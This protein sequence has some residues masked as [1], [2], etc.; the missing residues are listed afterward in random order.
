[1]PP[2]LA[3][4]MIASS[5]LLVPAPLL[6]AAPPMP[7]S[8]VMQ[9]PPV[10]VMS[11]RR[12]CTFATIPV[13]PARINGRH[14]AGG[15][16][17]ATDTGHRASEAAQGAAPQPR[18][19]RLEISRRR[20]LSEPTAAT[21]PAGLNR[22]S[23]AEPVYEARSQEHSFQRPRITTTAQTCPGRHACRCRP[24]HRLGAVLCARRPPRRLAAHR[25]SAA[26]HGRHPVATAA[27]PVR[28]AAAAGGRSP[29]P[30]GRALPPSSPRAYPP[31]APASLSSWPTD[32]RPAAQPQCYTTQYDQ[33]LMPADV[34]QCNLSFQGCRWG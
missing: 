25:G 12:V 21:W 8:I 1:M 24:Q 20:L 27:S 29:P 13:P 22:S 34:Q 33:A 9:P 19:P 17:L 15:Y 26:R 10:C 28:P 32:S 14:I 18:G 4:A 30:C 2:P 11:L 23:T 3:A 31:S 16:A 6:V 5:R 7:L